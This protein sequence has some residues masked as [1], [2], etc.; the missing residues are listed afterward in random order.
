[1]AEPIPVIFDTDPGVDDALAVAMAASCAAIEVLALTSCGGNVPAALAAQNASR[2]A[3][4][5]DD[6]PQVGIGR[7]VG[8]NALSIHGEDG[9][10]GQAARF[11]PSSAPD[12]RSAELLIELARAHAGHLTVIAIGPF[13]ILDTRIHYR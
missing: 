7:N 5:F 2:L 6:P 4:L 8:A 13:V 11:S 3:Q 10:A 12:A 9:L 1:M